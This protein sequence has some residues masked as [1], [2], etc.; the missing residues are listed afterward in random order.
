MVQSS[1][2]RHM[3]SSTSHSVNRVLLWGFCFVFSLLEQNL[4]N[5]TGSS[6][7]H[8]WMF[9]IF[10]QQYSEVFKGTEL[11]SLLAVE[12]QQGRVS[13][14]AQLMLS[15]S[16]LREV[17]W[18]LST[19]SFLGVTGIAWVY[20]ELCCDHRLIRTWT[21]GGSAWQPSS[22]GMAEGSLQVGDGHILAH[23]G[24]SQVHVW[25]PVDMERV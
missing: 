7:Q 5:W 8:T 23:G 21:A 17:I 20:H 24:Q 12:G 3:E 15:V 14:N 10:R 4:G 13:E 25:P 11:H 18:A 1:F 6:L 2:S 9:V 19:A 16:W 22:E